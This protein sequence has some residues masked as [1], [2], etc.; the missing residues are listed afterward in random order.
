MKIRNRI[1]VFLGCFVILLFYQ[2]TI[3]QDF[4]TELSSEL[5]K[6]LNSIVVENELPGITFSLLFDDE[7]Q[8]NL[9]AGYQDRQ[10]K[11]PMQVDSKML[12]GSVGKIFFSTLAL[13]MVQDGKLN[14]D[15]LASKYLGDREWF[16]TF[17]NHS[18]IKIINL[19]NHT[20]GL[21]RHLFQPEFLQEF[22]KDPLEKR[23]PEQC[24]QSIAN[25][26][27]VHPVGAG[28]AY[29]DTNYI[30]LGLI[31]E[32]MT[33]EDIYA[34]VDTELLQPLHL[35]NTLPAVDRRIAGL[36][37]GYIGP[38]NPF[39]LPEKVMGD[40]GELLV[41]PAFEWT[42]GGFATTP[43]DL[44]KMV[45]FIH[46]GDYL[47]QETKDLLTSAVNM[48]TGQPYD[49]GYGLGS[50]VWSKNEDTRYGH[51]GFF[52]GYVS[53]VEYSKN[54]QYALAIQVNYDG[55]YAYLQQF[56]FDLEQVIEGHLDE[57]DDYKIRQNFKKQEACWN[58][59]DIACYM[60]AYATTEHIQTASR[61]GITYGYDNIIGNYRKYFPKERMGK[62]YFD[63]INTRRLS[64][65]L[66]FV[67]GRFNLRFPDREDL[68]RG[69]FSVNMK[70]INGKWLM[71]TDH[72]S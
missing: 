69:W 61:G 68:A 12:S 48:A 28:W 40:T 5:Q 30:L 14:L 71:I 3:A 54:R 13:N 58:N 36:V 60:E 17:P 70:K 11:L 39:Q 50:F 46:E 45:K 66:Y 43:S 64:D 21:P 31:I 6:E 34:L 57:I 20:S 33:G 52:P 15:D 56:L 47:N 26:P 72:S 67:T 9:A 38:Q 63:N 2:A 62:L 4:Y 27:A 23:D 16:N 7:H 25:K 35:K 53:H 51:S 49:Q 65:N 19:L 59:A 8:I 55:A 24:I 1:T 44:T 42:G 32:Q 22:L 18:E 37:Q 29:S 41:H 10:Q